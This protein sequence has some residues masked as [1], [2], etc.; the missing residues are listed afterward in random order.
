MRRIAVCLLFL[1]CVVSIASGQGSQTGT[2][3]GTVTAGGNALPGV[4]VTIESQAL[5]GKRTTT[6][7]ANG[8]YAFRFLPPGSYTVTFELQGMK[9]AVQ[10]TNVAL[11]ATTKTDAPMEVT[12]RTETVNVSGRAENA[13]LED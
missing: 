10:T 9:K 6:S 2:L 12:S 8:D 4:T 13:T 3:I 7:G 5:Q 1:S 11:G